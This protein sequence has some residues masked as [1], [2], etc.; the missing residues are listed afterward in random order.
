M[1][2]R[3]AHAREDRLRLKL[4]A[5]WQPRWQASW[6][7]RH[8][9]AWYQVVSPA[10]DCRRCPE[11]WRFPL[12]PSLS[13]R[14]DD[15]L[16]GAQQSLLW[17]FVLEDFVER[18]GGSLVAPPREW[19]EAEIFEEGLGVEVEEISEDGSEDERIFGSSCQ[20]T[21]MEE[22]GALSEDEIF[23]SG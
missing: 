7:G 5:G 20:L 9:A 11:L 22:E 21:S 18:Y 17:A 4:L 16:L 6:A 14:P 1:G 23:G 15:S 10:E 3:Q 19:V 8:S 12:R 13:W 2:R